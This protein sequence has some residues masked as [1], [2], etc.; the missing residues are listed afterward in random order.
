MKSSKAVDF[1]DRLLI[2]LERYGLDPSLIRGQAMD[3]CSTMSGHIGELK[4]LIRE[5]SSSAL[6]VHCMAHRL[7]LVLVKAATNSTHVK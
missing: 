6:Y 2:L 7:N 1:R 5:I 3:G 4:V